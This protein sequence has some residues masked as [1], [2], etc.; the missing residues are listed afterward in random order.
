M[1]EN[2]HFKKLVR[3]RM[4]KTGESYSTARRQVLNAREAAFRKRVVQKPGEL[5]ATA[6][7]LLAAISAGDFP[8]FEWA[9][10][11]GCLGGCDFC[12]VEIV[13]DTELA[14][15][16]AEHYGEPATFETF[17]QAIFDACDETSSGRENPFLCSYHED[18]MEDERHE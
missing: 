13:N 6:A 15:A 14:E 16:L 1:S 10:Y 3:E 4:K 17:A 18:V 9:S 8:L 12:G 7:D 2:K 11:Y 5:P